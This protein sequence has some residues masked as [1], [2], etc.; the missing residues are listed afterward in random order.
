MDEPHVGGLG[1]T[2]GGNPLACRAALAVL[3]ILDDQAMKKSTELGEKVKA[4]FDALYDKYEIIGDVRGLGPMMGMELVKDRK[5]KEPA[6]DETKALV[7][8]LY[9]RGLITI[10]CG[11]YG[12]VIR[13]LMP[14][15]ITDDQLDKGFEMLEKG[16]SEI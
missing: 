2:Y 13:T 14:L 7:K 4:R 6:G 15:V 8:K 12:N 1:G 10:S 16:L 3:E 9:E 11:H 5:T